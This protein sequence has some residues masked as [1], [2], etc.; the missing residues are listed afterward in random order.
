MA[1]TSRSVPL[2]E[3]V[4]VVVVVWIVA[5]EVVR[6][7]VAVVAV[8]IVVGV[9]VSVVVIPFLRRRQVHYS[10]HNEESKSEGKVSNEQT[11]KKTQRGLSTSRIA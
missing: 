1:R 9:R 6:V 8:V 7:A 5:V 10:N 4:V 2:R 3:E 11:E